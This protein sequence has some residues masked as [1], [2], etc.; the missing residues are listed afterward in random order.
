MSKTSRRPARI[1][2]VEDDPSALTLLK[3]II[4][5]KREYEL[6][7]ARNGREGLEKARAFRPDLVIS[8]YVMPEMDGIDLCQA[9][10]AD[11][12]LGNPIF[13]M[14]SS[15]SESDR[16]AQGLSLGA[17]EYLA[18]P[19]IAEELLAKVNAFLRIKRLQDQLRRDKEE[20][21]RL[22]AQLEQSFL[23]LV[24]LLTRLIDLRVPG[25][26]DRGERH[27]TAAVEIAKRIGLSADEQRDIQI[28]GLLREIGKIG[29]PEEIARRNQFELEPEEWLVFAHHPILAEMSTS[30]ISRLHRASLILRHQLENLDGTGHPDHLSGNEIPIGSRILR[31]VGAYEDYRARTQP[32]RP[33]R[34]MVIA[35]GEEHAGVFDAAVVTALAEYLTVVDDPAWMADN[36]YLRAEELREGM[37]LAAD[38]TTS[39][40]LK[41][42]PAGATL[43]PRMVERIQAHHEADPIVAGIAVLRERPAPDE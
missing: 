32:S 13:M 30:D 42:L 31:C 36:R 23:D 9:L 6:D 2:I 11:S 17:D 16:K 40:G 35:M 37:T 38:L 8:D 28:A 20:L 29:L 25:A 18:K 4:N 12:E 7:V 1:L 39:S 5:S 22:H 3:K 24:R 15:I 14:L 19:P 41:L 27:A 43:T 21:Q 26:H 34:E 33:H 10:K